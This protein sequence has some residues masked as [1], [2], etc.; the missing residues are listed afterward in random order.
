MNTSQ[1]LAWRAAA[2]IGLCVLAGAPAP[3]AAGT[4]P[5]GYC[6]TLDRL[7]AAQDL[8]F[9]YLEVP[10]QAVAALSAEEFARLRERVGALR[11]PV[12][13]ANSFVPATVR[14]TGPEVSDER[15][16][17]YVRACLGRLADLGV[18]TVVFGSGN[19]RRV[20]DGFPRD[21][22]VAQIVA[23]GRMA[24]EEA[25]RHGIVIALEPLRRQE[26]NIVN[27]VAEGLPIVRAVDRPAFGILVDFYHLSEEKED[28]AVL[29]EAG[30]LLRHVHV[31]N[32]EGR[33]FPK[34]LEEAAYGPFVAGLRAAGYRGGVSIEARTENLAGD[35]PAA[36]GLL[37][38]L[39]SPAA[40][41]GAAPRAERGSP[42]VLADRYPET[43]HAAVLLPRER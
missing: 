2:A 31:A 42:P 43:E 10:A 34:E 35:A 41:A 23:F 40:P 36:I 9:D 13:A 21:D 25:A 20:P 24:A 29:R 15:Q 19:A 16:R 39:L 12:R 27:T 26:S 32:P 5:I 18:K 30:S 22:A 14:I 37:R 28:P 3:R 7:E 11:T 38:R 1:R 33:V 6:V 8:G 17:E 4:T